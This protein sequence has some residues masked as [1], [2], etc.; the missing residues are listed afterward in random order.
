MRIKSHIA[1]RWLGSIHLVD[2]IV[3]RDPV[4]KGDKQLTIFDQSASG[5]SVG[6]IDLLLLADL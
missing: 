2:Q 6:N 3:F 4:D 5:L 1:I